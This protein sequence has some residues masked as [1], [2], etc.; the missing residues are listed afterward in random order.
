M[1]ETTSAADIRDIVSRAREA[2]DAGHT[3]PLAWRRHILHRLSELLQSRENELV[4]A[5][6]ADFARPRFEAWA[7]EIGYTRAELD[8][9]YARLSLWMRSRRVPTPL[10]FQPGISRIMPEPRGVT[11][12]IS[13]WNYPVQLLLMPMIAS[14][15][16]GN[17]VVGK[18]SELTPCT[19]AELARL[20]RDIDDPAVALVQGSALEG[21]ELLKNKFDYILYTGGRNGAKN[22]LR[23]AAEHLTPVTLELGGKSPV[24][25]SRNANISMAARRIAWGKFFN[26]G[27]TCI[28]PDYV[29]VEHAVHDQLIT[30]LR[31]CIKGFFGDDPSMSPDFGRIVNDNHFHRLEKL[32]YSGTIATGGQADAQTRFIAPTVLTGVLPTDLVMQDEV[33]GPVLPVLGVNSLDNA[34]DIARS[35][36]KPLA[37]Y[38]FSNS[39]SECKSLIRRIPSGGVCVNGTLVHVGNSYLPFGGVGESGM[40]RYHG[41][42]GFDAFS[43]FRAIH[44]RT[45]PFDP[46]AMYPPYSDMKERVLRFGFSLPDFRGLTARLYSEVH[47]VRH[48]G[49]PGSP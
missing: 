17:A 18:P 13:P 7:T 30:A 47:P 15:S 9:V 42:F 43:H 8:H 46:P 21:A 26:A 48:G 24:I 28:A 19:S 34:V 3:R 49:D 37:L 6:I 29:L 27:Q 41:K 45:L 12:V 11:C 40:G 33:F 16:A 31:A 38:V 44:T 32:L 35:G 2:F 23:A 5:V 36:S 10:T 1:N 39:K 14:I 22:V 25:V 4:A 20:F